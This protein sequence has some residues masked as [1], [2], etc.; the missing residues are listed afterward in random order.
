[1]S[2]LNNACI[3][4]MIHIT[5]QDLPLCCPMNDTEIYNAHPRVYLTFENNEANCPYCNTKYILNHK[6]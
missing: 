1:M 6:D 2:K 4:P 3:Y 5:K